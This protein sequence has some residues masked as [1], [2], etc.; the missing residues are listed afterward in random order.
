[1]YSILAG[2]KP[3]LHKL[4]A[5]VHILFVLWESCMVSA[6]KQF[7]NTNKNPGRIIKH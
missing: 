6:R 1:M 5:P 2:L 4:I 3:E 7:V